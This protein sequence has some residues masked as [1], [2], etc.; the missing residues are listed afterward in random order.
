VGGEVLK[1]QRYTGATAEEAS[2]LRFAA[3]QSGIDVDTM[4]KSLGLLSKNLA[5]TKL[6]KLGLGLKD[7]SGKAL[8]LNDSLLKI[9]ERFQSMA[10]G[11]EKTAL[12]MQLFGKSGA[13]LIPFL[14]KGA[15]GIAEL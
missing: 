15:D 12:A 9:A 2:R 14:N 6:D 1:R 5:G 4:T 7:A 8:P 13:Q 11:P 10:N 3:K